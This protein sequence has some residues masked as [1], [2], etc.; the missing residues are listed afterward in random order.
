M[1]K[2]NFWTSRKN[3]DAIIEVGMQQHNANNQTN[4]M[5]ML[6]LKF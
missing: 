4:D 2:Y 3:I 1:R 5:E 6:L